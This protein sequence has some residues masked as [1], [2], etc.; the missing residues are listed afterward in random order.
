STGARVV[1][2]ARCEGEAPSVAA[3]P[4]DLRPVTLAV[5]R[6]RIRPDAAQTLA[7]FAEQGVE[8]K[9]ISCDNPATVAS[10]AR[11]FRLLDD[12]VDG[13]DARTVPE[14]GQELAVALGR[15]R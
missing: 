4:A 11:T 14:D 15:A 3:L 12:E 8:V 7:Y 2:L 5:L 13:V 10:I 9:V 1:L 6:E